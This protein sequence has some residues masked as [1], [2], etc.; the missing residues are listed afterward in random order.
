MTGTTAGTAPAPARDGARRRRRAGAVYLVGGAIGLVAAAVLV[1]ERLAMLSDP[2]YVPSCSINPVISCGSVMESAQASVFG[3]PNPL[4]GL[5]AF[6]VVVTG[7]VA[8]LAGFEPPAWF[9]VGMQVGS[10]LGLV[11]VHWLIYQ[12][13]AEIHA[14]CPYCMVVWL[15]TI[16]VFWYA[17]LESLA[18]V[19]PARPL[20]ATLRRF[21]SSVPAIWYLLILVAAAWTFRGFFFGPG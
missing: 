10:T 5:V 1:L 6:A 8:M 16:T 19:R 18:L 4:I 11:F 15:V 9:T 20:V 7:G 2:G 13:L 21:H 3:F 17:T 14:L 12:S